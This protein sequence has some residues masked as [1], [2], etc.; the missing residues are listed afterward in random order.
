VNVASSGNAEVSR[1]GASHGCVIPL[2]GPGP[3]WAAWAATP[4]CEVWGS[5]WSAR[6]G[7][8]PPLAVVGAQNLPDC[9]LPEK[10]GMQGAERAFG[11]VHWMS[12]R[13]ST[14]FT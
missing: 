5:V 2:T 8:C 1:S 10:T 7:R 4:G 13:F 12:A 9:D 3:L 11:A 6:R 14:T